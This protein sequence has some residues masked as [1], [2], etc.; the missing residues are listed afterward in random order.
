M[1]LG[2]LPAHAA[3]TC[4]KEYGAL[5]PGEPCIP[6]P[7][8]NYLY[9]LNKSGEGKIE[10][11]Q[12]ND[13]SEKHLSEITI[14]GHM[15]GVFL[16]GGA[17]GSYKKEDGARVIKD[18][19]EKMDTSLVSNCK[20]LAT[21]FEKRNHAANDGQNV[22]TPKAPKHELKSENSANSRAPQFEIESVD[23][24]FDQDELTD[25]SLV[26]LRNLSKRFAHPQ[27]SMV[28]LIPEFRDELQPAQ[29]AAKNENS[30]VIRRQFAIRDVL[31][32]S[33]FQ[34]DQITFEQ[35]S[36]RIVGDILRFDNAKKRIE[37]GMMVEVW[38]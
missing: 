26:S 3:E 20:Y 30:L 29:E 32:A 10:I 17:G 15:S 5:N 12:H 2:I 6:K 1:I 11:V 28:T 14:D 18:I 13:N 19:Q 22:S 38:P 27:N 36:Y 35:H 9:C 4:Q 21:R 8:L 25:R 24:V 23:F 16:H 7:L 33:G 34:S 31:V 37:Q